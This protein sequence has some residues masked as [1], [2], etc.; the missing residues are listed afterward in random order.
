MTWAR[1]SCDRLANLRAEFDDRLVHLRLD[2]FLKGDFAAL[3]NLLDMRTELT[4]L[5]IYDRELLL[6]PESKGVVFEISEHDRN[7]FFRP[8][9]VRGQTKCPVPQPGIN[10][11]A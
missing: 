10:A 6:D 1:A 11:P 3:E 7:W 9:S 2:L 5:G 4:R 8:L